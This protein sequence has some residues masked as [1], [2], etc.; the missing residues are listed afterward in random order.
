MAEYL[1]LDANTL[2][3]RVAR[4]E[5]IVSRWQTVVTIVEDHIESHGR[6]KVDFV[7]PQ[8][9]VTLLSLA[10]AIQAT[11]YERVSW[12]EQ[13]KTESLPYALENRKRQQDILDEKRR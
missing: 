11:I 10:E 12:V 8:E 3:R 4:S 5:F 1:P 6:D 7:P 2:S 13:M 9:P